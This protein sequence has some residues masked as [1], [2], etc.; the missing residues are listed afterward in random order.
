MDPL[1][2]AAV[3]GL[4]FAG[5]RLSNTSE[6]PL[7]QD[8]MVMMKPTKPVTSFDLINKNFAQQDR[9]LDPRTTLPDAGRVYNDFRLRPKEAVGNMQEIS[10]VTRRFPYGQ[11][12]YDLYSRQ[13]VSGKMNNVPPIE[14]VNVGPGLGIGPDE[15]AGGGFHEFFRVLPANINEERLTTLRGT[16]S[17]PANTIG[18]PSSAVVKAGGP[19]APSITHEAKDTK[20]WHRD[21]AQNSGQG[22]GGVL[23]APEGRPDQIKTRR[24]TIR[25]ETG[26]RT[27]DTLQLGTANYFVKEPY[28]TGKDNYTDTRLT[29]GTD[30][31]SNTDREGNGQRMNVR[32]DPI[33]Q[34]GAITNVRPES[35]PFPVQGADPQFRFNPYKNADYYK[36]NAF[37]MNANPNSTPRALDIAIQQLDKN[38]LAMTPLS[39][40]TAA[41]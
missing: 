27:G 12:V 28:A 11:P 33:G 7:T 18:G 38:E 6:T 35:V 41:K 4:V 21:P 1:A 8:Q 2:L 15:P 25:D 22:Q 9:P 34:L 36:F 13:G 37:R 5:Q 29:R 17:D 30:N 40:M 24:M 32:A 19:V 14:Q 39:R 20:A 10:P 31:R 16:F 23:R 3:V 26:E